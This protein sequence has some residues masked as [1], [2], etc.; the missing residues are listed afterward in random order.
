M[1]FNVAMLNAI[2]DNRSDISGPYPQ[3][4][5]AER[6]NTT[7]QN[8]SQILSGKQNITLNMAQ[9]IAEIYDFTPEQ[10]YYCF[11]IPV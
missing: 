8:I 7:R 6:L 1:N 4:F 10:F 11:G 2:I 5:L 9:R 3:K